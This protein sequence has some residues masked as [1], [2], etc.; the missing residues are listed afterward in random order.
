MLASTVLPLRPAPTIDKTLSEVAGS[1]TVPPPSRDQ[2]WH[3]TVA[4]TTD[5][6]G[7]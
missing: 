7:P 6:L 4:L 1:A 2:G 5:P 3:A